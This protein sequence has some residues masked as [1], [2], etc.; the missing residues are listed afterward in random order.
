MIEYNIEF[1][2]ESSDLFPSLVGS[3]NK[4]SR[5]GRPGSFA[6]KIEPSGSTNFFNKLKS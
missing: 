4:Q 3:V 5:L 6:L 2:S 1:V